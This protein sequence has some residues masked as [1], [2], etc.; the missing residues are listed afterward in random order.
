[1]ISTYRTNVSIFFLFIDRFVTQVRTGQKN[2]DYV[3][4]PTSLC[5]KTCLIMFSSYRVPPLV[6]RSVGIVERKSNQG[7]YTDD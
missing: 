3:K 7:A 5:E 4:R 1:M 6:S 2:S